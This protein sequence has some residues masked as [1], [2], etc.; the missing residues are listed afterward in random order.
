MNALELDMK[1]RLMLLSV[2]ASGT[3]ILF[4]WTRCCQDDFE[5][6][7]RFVPVGENEI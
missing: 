1:L 7:S 5:C 6:Y 3:S 4:T 2:N